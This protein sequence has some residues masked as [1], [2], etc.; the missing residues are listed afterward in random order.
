MYSVLTWIWRLKV[1]QCCW[2]ELTAARSSPTSSSTLTTTS[3][4]GR[5]LSP[6]CGRPRPAGA[7]CHSRPAATVAPASSRSRSERCSS[8]Q[9]TGS[10]PS[11]SATVALWPRKNY[12][13]RRLGAGLYIRV[14]TSGKHGSNPSFMYSVSNPPKVFNIFHIFHKRLRIF[15]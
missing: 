5:P 10:P 14:A 8:R 7:R 4:R 3:R 11:C 6:S 1:V 15:N 2:T 9:T 13:R 12:G